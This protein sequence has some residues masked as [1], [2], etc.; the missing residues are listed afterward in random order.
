MSGRRAIGRREHDVK[1]PVLVG[2]ASVIPGFGYLLLGNLRSAVY[3][4]LGLLM[5]VL[6]YFFSPVEILWDVAVIAFL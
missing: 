3:V 4:W 6:V 5:A 1:H 2:I